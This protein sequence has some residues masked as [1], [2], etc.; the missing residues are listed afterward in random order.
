MAGGAFKFG[1]KF[2]TRTRAVTSK[3]EKGKK[4]KQLDQFQKVKPGMMCLA[5]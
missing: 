5:R 4:K 3:N 2:I 1:S